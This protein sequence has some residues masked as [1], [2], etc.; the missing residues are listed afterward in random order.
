MN[1]LLYT[2]ALIRSLYDQGEDYIDSFWPFTIQVLKENKFSDTSYVQ[3]Q[4]KERCGLTI[5][6]HVLGT[7]LKRARRKEYL[8]YRAE[9]SEETKREL[10]KLTPKGSK[11]LDELEKQEDV[12]RRIND[13][14]GDIAIFFSERKI[15]LNNT[16][17]LDLLLS[18]LHEN[19]QPLREFLDPA[20]SPASYSRGFGPNINILFEYLKIAERERPSKYQTIQDILFGSIISTI[21]SAGEEHKIHDLA[22]KKF[23]QCKVLLDTN[24]VLSLLGLRPASEI[25]EGAK[26]LFQLVKNYNCV[27]RVF[28]FTI[29]EITRVLSSYFT[30]EYRYSDNVI[31]D[32]VCSFLKRN[33]W[34]KTQLREYIAN[35]EKTLNK[36]G[37]GVELKRDINLKTYEPKNAQLRDRIVIYKKD[38]NL[39]AQNHDLAAIESIREIRRHSVMQIESAS[40]IFLTSDAS[41]GRFDFE[42]YGHKDDQTISEVILDRLL[43]NILWLKMPHSKPTLKSII[44]SHSRNLFIRGKVWAKFYDVLGELKRNGEVQDENISMLFYHGYIE[45]SLRHFE[46]HDT[47]IITREFILEEIAK[48]SKHYE[49]EVDKKIKEREAEFIDKLKS[50]TSKIIQEKNLQKDREWSEKLSDI[51]INIKNVAKNEARKR[52]ILF[53]ITA[54]LVLAIPFLLAISTNA[55][56]QFGRICDIVTAIVL[57]FGVAIGSTGKLWDR[58]EEVF[59]NQIYLKRIAE[60]GLAK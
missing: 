49:Q 56:D 8:E 23:K 55:W 35:I 14:L 47:D 41:L 11:Y 58:L 19:S 59:L 27:L 2:Y 36:I 51:K 24:F 25:V 18:V 12:E 1:N 30:E 54:A 16:Q 9:W 39:M 13:L 21:I 42:E 32:D 22:T 33:G 31:V 53:R 50:S 60:A 40:A 29:S 15:S 45:D 6:L 28:D 38:Q 3:N 5:P 37:I 34:T 4:I 48:A 20:K 52:I 17:I 46:D 26:E 57:I 44:A 43:T 7:I 10:Y